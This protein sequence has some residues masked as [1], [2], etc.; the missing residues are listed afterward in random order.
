MVKCPHNGLAVIDLGALKLPMPYYSIID[1][2]GLE[3]ASSKRY[4]RVSLCRLVIGH[5]H[6]VRFCREVM[7]GVEV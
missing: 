5:D 3:R 4:P 7:R 6:L 1:W 2:F